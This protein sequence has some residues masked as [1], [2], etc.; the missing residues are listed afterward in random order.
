MSTLGG[1][2]GES[3]AVPAVTWP[4]SVPGQRQRPSRGWVTAIV[5]VFD[6]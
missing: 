2:T 6:S 3:A 4:I 5:E 1:C